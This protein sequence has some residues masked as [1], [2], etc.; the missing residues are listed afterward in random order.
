[1]RN[2]FP[3]KRYEETVWISDARLLDATGQPAA[4]FAHDE[5]VRIVLDCD[6]ERLAAGLNAGIVVK[7]G[8]D[9]V[10]F[11]SEFDLPALPA[12]TK[13]FRCEAMIPANLLTPGRYVFTVFVH[14]PL[15][16]IVY[17]SEDAMVMSIFDAGS[18]LAQYEG[19]TDLGCVF[20]DCG[21]QV[22][23]PPV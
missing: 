2:L 19:K 16:R 17:L 7:D 18:P 13:T 21:W 10:I 6:V 12:T 4:A 8:R 3:G 23:P 14:V 11:R 5:P 20:V 22:Q 9:R 15:V 1:M